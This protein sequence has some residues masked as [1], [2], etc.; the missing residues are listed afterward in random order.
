MGQMGPATSGG[1]GGFGAS[2]FRGPER[3]RAESTVLLAYRN[4]IAGAIPAELVGLK[5]VKSFFF[6][7]KFGKGTL[8]KIIDCRPSNPYMGEAGPT[9]LAGLCHS[10]EFS[11]G[12]FW[13]AE[14]DA[15]SAF[16]RVETIREMWAY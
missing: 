2:C 3:E 8:R 9:E 14:G 13:A 15:E 4:Y 12:C 10:T 11:A 6:L 1:F 16:T 7:E 5:V